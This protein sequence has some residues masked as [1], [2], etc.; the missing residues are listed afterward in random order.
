VA[1]FNYARMTET[2]S[3]LLS[4]FNQGE[5][6]YIQPGEQTGPEYDPTYGPETEW[7]V[8]GTVR[9]VAQQYVSEGYISASDLQVTLSVF[10][11]EP[12]TSGELSIDGRRHQIIE[13]RAIPGAGTVVSW[14]LFCK[15]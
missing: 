5:L 13:V 8:S 7:P 3:R 14:V 9:G 10:G 6:I 1:K 11:T 15:A 12:T 4:D 2:A